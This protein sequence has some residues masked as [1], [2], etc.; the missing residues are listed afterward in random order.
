MWLLTTGHAIA[1]THV[2][3]LQSLVV[4]QSEFGDRPVGT[5]YPGGRWAG[6]SVRAVSTAALPPSS[7]PGSGLKE[8]PEPTKKGPIRGSRAHPG[9]GPPGS[10]HTQGHG[11]IPPPPHSWQH[12]LGLQSP[13]G[14]TQW[15]PQAYLWELLG[16]A[17]QVSRKPGAPRPVGLPTLIQPQLIHVQTPGLVFKWISIRW[18]HRIIASCYFYLERIHNDICK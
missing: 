9:L 17:L 6:P 14:K 1:G 7:S 16:G 4:F 15:G 18:A 3:V 5:M 13:S 2:P 11:T 8:G 10:A 12:T